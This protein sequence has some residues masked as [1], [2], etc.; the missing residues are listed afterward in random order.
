MQVVVAK[1]ILKA[2][3]SIASENLERFDAEGV[4]AINMLGSPGSGKTTMLEQ[5]ARRFEGRLRAGVIEGDLATSK[6][7]ERI[8]KLNWP[9]VQINTGGGCHL[10]ANMVANA[11]QSLDLS[12]LDVVFIENVGNLVC[13]SGYMLGERL[14]FVVLST[15]EGDDKVSKYPPMFQRT[16]AVVVN[17]AD[18]LEFT[19]F[20]IDSMRED[21]AK[22]NPESK[23]FVASA[24]T[25]DGFD[26]LAEWM[27]G[28]I[29]AWR[30]Q[31]QPA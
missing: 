20:N 7:A 15:T 12:Q 13:T 4:F 6:D 22:L 18:L 26:E 14:R 16:Q 17:K 27:I 2:N 30:K 24:R 25:G 10:E 29:E 23:I 8:D 21:V 31:M 11:L 28:E 9:V 3:D 1:D 5:L 19:D